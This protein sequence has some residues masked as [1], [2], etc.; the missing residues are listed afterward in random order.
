MTDLMLG[1][2]VRTRSVLARE[3]IEPPAGSRADVRREWRSVPT[4]PREGILVGVRHLQNGRII[5]ERESDGWGV[6]YITKTWGCDG[7]V[8]AALVAYDLYL[9]PTMVAFEEVEAA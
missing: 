5:V 3:T 9:T 6:G 2:R 8:K 7:V 4:D 1:A